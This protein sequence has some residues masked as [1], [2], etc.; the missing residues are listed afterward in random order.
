MNLSTARRPTGIVNAAQSAAGVLELSGVAGG[1]FSQCGDQI[2]ELR[3]RMSGRRDHSTY[4][5]QS[6][7][8]GR[9]NRLGILR[10]WQV[11]RQ[12]RA[13][14]ANGV[15][16]REPP[17]GQQIPNVRDYYRCD[18]S[19]TCGY[20]QCHVI[21]THDLRRRLGVRVLL[22]L[23]VVAVGHGG[24][25]LAAEQ[26]PDRH[27]VD[28][29][30]LEEFFEAGVAGFQIRK[31]DHFV[32]AF[33][34]PYAELQPLIGRIEGTYRA[35]LEFCKGARL[36]T[37]RPVERVRILFF[38]R[39]DDFISAAASSGLTTDDITGFYDPNRHVSVFCSVR[40][41]PWLAKINQRI[42]QTQ[43]R[44][45]GLDAGAVSASASL[46]QER[47]LRKALNELR[48]RRDALTEK[49]NRNVVQHEVAHQMFFTLGVHVQGAYNPLWLIEGLACVFEVPQP[50]AGGSRLR[51][52]HG[53]LGDLREAVGVPPHARSVSDADFEAALRTGSLVTLEELVSSDAGLVGPDANLRLGYAQAWGLVY[54]LH[55]EYREAFG[56]YILAVSR[57]QPGEPV[58]PARERREF[59]AA[60]GP[61]D[62][63]F[64]RRWI[65]YMLK[66]R[67]DRHEAG[68]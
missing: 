38:D 10:P 47:N 48:T 15:I 23:A 11:Y 16:E 60:F 62:G 50:G 24:Q 65:N 66:L 45:Q 55:R 8:G 64:Q 9:M 67:L 29:K 20:G 36:P 68:R 31:S 4:R 13:T 25:R 41:N 59:E 35:I 51:I 6:S 1:G 33:D 12:L 49:F 44:L 18:P 22:M 63:A 54:Y 43:E 3:F 58:G 30:L 53:R 52:T 34:T 27:P 28:P 2:G 39:F 5:S 46:R 21:G 57:R 40:A 56:G 17:L 61:L 32:I 7:C 42:T 14:R 26:V 37:P 19:R